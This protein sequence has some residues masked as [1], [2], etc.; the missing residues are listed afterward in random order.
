VSTSNRSGADTN[1]DVYIQLYGKE[2]CTE[3]KFLCASKS[4]RKKHFNKGNTGRVRVPAVQVCMWNNE[5]VF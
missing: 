2:V 3:K 4:E 5:L 1:A